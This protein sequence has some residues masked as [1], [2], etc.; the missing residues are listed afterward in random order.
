[1]KKKNGFTVVEL[2][3]SFSLVMVIVIFLFQIIISLREMYVNNGIKSALL[4]KQAI[5]TQKIYDDFRS[6]TITS[7]T[8]CGDNCITFSFDD[9]STTTLRIDKDQNLFEY[10]DYATKLVDGS[11]FGDFVV[12]TETV[13]DVSPAQYDS[14]IKIV[15]PV[16]NRLLEGNFGV[17]AV[18]QYNSNFT[19]IG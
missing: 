13:P 8:S 15:I 9:T 7:F 5:M 12:S 16:T 4:N 18:Y 11:S 17:T 10:G 1:M 19:T 2:V 3:V 14:M 6:K